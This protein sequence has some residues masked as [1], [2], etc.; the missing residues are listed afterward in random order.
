MGG[1]IGS[2]VHGRRGA[3]LAVRGTALAQRVPEGPGAYAPGTWEPGAQGS[4]AQ[5]SGTQGSG[6]QES[7]REKA[8]VGGVR[9]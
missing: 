9:S 8:G 1:F 4:G 7:G 2:L 5:G 6:T 3:F